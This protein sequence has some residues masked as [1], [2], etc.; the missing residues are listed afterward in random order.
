MRPPMGT[1]RCI[2][3]PSSYSLD[4]MYETRPTTSS[5]TRRPI[6]PDE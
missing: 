4:L 3:K 5:A 6:A 1:A 2:S